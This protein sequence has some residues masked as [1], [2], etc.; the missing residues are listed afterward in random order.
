LTVNTTACVTPACCTFH[1]FDRRLCYREHSLPRARPPA[2]PRRVI[3]CAN[4]RAIPRA[5]TWPPSEWVASS[6]TAGFPAAWVQ[7]LRRLGNG[8]APAISAP[9]ARHRQRPRLDPAARR[10][11][12]PT[13]P[14][15]EA[16]LNN[17]R[18]GDGVY[19]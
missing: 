4:A 16:E 19:Q 14:T 13:Q 1:L 17:Q 11:S 18:V 5:R 2:W 10:S 6:Q 3:V 9:P 15:N 7:A 12:W 8:F